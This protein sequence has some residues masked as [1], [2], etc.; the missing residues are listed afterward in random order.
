MASAPEST[1]PAHGGVPVPV[2]TKPVVYD[3]NTQFDWPEVVASAGPCSAGTYVGQSALAGKLDCSTNA[4]A[5]DSTNGTHG[6]PPFNGTF[7]GTLD[8]V[9]HT[10]TGTWSLAPTGSTIAC[11]GPWSAV[12]QP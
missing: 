8:R 7:G 5:A 2:D 11:V 3:P 4:F 10:L 9:A 1:V 12:R 6:T